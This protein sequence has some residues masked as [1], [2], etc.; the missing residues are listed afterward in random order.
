MPSRK[1]NKGRVLEKGESQR[2]DGTYMYRWTD[3]S[4]KRQTIYART[5]NELRQKELQVTRTEIISGVSWESNKITV[6]ELIDRY[7]SLKKVR[8]T[9]DQKYRY[10]INMLDKIQILD[11]PIKDIKTSLAKQYM[12]TLSNMGYSYG[13]VQNAKTLLKPA[14]QMAVEDDYIVKNPF[15]FTLSNIIENDSKQRFSMSEEEEKHYIEFIS[16]HGW[17]RHI[18]DDVVILLNTGMRVSELYG[19]TF[20][21]VDLK[22]RRINVNKQLHRIEGKYVVLPPKSKAGNRILAM[23]DATRK[24]FINR[25]TEV[26][27]K[28]EYVVDGYTGFVF[29][30][31]LGF[32]KTRRNLEGSM[33]E[34]RK[35]HIELGLGELPQITPHVLRHTFCSRMVE[36]G[37]N[38]K[39]LQLVMGHSD[40]STTLDVYTHK[41]PDDVA[42]E[43]EQYIAM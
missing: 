28:V 35:K 32:P 33:R 6:R 13:T 30:N 34:V 10:L 18:Y 12:I 15:L 19:L 20:K 43:M 29:I 22:N 31:H 36:K 16:N 8:I 23:N 1:D 14:F 26:R 9:T 11:I 37:M 21:D 42:K 24:A 5:L 27:P 4:K 40:I 41:K 2:N 3:L 25:R 39:T 7:L 17:F 38:V